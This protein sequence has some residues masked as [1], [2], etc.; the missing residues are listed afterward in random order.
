MA[1]WTLLRLDEG[2]ER[3]FTKAGT[4][5]YVCVLHPGMAGQV[6]VT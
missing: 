4:Y 5:P 1:L 2:E 3:P 6:D